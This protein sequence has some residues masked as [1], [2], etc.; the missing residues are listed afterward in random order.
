MPTS[1]PSTSA[2]KSW[3]PVAVCRR[4]ANSWCDAML[5]LKKVTE[6]RALTHSGDVWG[7]CAFCHGDAVGP[8]EHIMMGGY[9]TVTAS[10]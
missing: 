6:Y 2:M 9:A 8:G 4:V 1:A 5:C 3:R 10:D 7:T